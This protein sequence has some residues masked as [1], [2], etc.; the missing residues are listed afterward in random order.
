MP[1]GYDYVEP[2]IEILGECVIPG[3]KLPVILPE[4]GPPQEHDP[5]EM[6]RTYLV[7]PSSSP[8]ESFY[9]GTSAS[10]LDLRTWSSQWE[11]DRLAFLELQK[12]LLPIQVTE[13]PI[14]ELEYELAL[15]HC[16]LSR[17][18]Y[19]LASERQKMER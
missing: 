8:P 3:R 9:L 10:Q 14:P 16:K 12:S 13:A 17:L 7:R 6:H 18:D 19:R 4:H 15:C 11:S 1:A 2:V 5:V